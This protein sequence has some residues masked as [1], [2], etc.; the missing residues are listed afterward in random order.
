MSAQAR[1]SDPSQPTVT[2]TATPSPAASSAAPAAV[3]T[4]AGPA[5]HRAAAYFDLDKTILATSSTWALG[6]PM[7]RSGLISS[8]ALAYGLVAQLPYLLVGA[9]TR[10]STTLME[11]LA[12]MSAGISRRDLVD[13]VEG[14]LAT[15][16]EPAVYAEALDLIEAHHRAGH[17]VVVVSASI[18][19]MV[20]PIA[21][22]VGADRAVATRMEVGE[23][24]LFTGR[25]ARSMLHSE[26]VVA[27]HEDAAAHGIDPA[28]S[29]AYS[30]SISDEPMLSAVGHPVAV[31]PDR[32]LRRM[33]QERDWPVRDFARPVRLR[34]RW[35]PPTLSTRASLIA[36]AAGVLAVG[37]AAAWLVARRGA[38]RAVGA[39]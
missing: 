12:L 2:S 20:T 18:T 26:K 30:D 22:L 9:G 32:E 37:G 34:P 35:E 36:G 8:R 38:R 15:A 25:I 11:H 4:P 39:A 23:D 7:R 16:I 5:G 1:A 21:R 14:A 13:V 28:R 29:W 10:Q 33:A 19:E 6:T 31:N 24:G 17:D 27:L 3:S